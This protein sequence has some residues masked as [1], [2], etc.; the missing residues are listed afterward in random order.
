M[1]RTYLWPLMIVCSAVLISLALLGDSRS[2]G[3]NDDTTVLSAEP[4]DSF[5]FQLELGDRVVAEYTE[6]FGLG[7][8]N[9]IEE[10]VIQ[11]NGGAVK[12]KTPGA[13]EWHDITLRRQGSPD[14]DVWAWREAM[15]DGKTDDAVRDGAIVMFATGSAEPLAQWNF[16]KGWPASLTIEGSVQELTIVHEGLQRVVPSSH[17]PPKRPQVEW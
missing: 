8:S 7:S 4:S 1:R 14:E 13:L 17:R 5:I 12:Q 15:E 9:E 3:Q 11:A 16:S 6:C 10:S 2:R